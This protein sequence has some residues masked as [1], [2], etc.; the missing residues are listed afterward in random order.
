MSLMDAK[1]LLGLSETTEA[2]PVLEWIFNR[3]EKAFLVRTKLAEV[4]E[5]LDYVVTEVT[6]IRYNRRDA[7]GMKTVSDEGFSATYSDDI[8]SEYAKDISEYLESL[9]ADPA[10]VGKVRF[11]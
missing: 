9:D 10:S 4:P 6:L 5:Q 1:L 7:E 3:V 2:D 11:L 8:F